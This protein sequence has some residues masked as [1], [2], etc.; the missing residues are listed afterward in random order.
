[1]KIAGDMGIPNALLSLFRAT[2]NAHPIRIDALAFAQAILLAI[3]F[4]LFLQ[5]LYQAYFQDNEPQDTSLARGLVLLTP[6]LTAIFWMVQAS[7][8]LGLAL[9]GSLS[10]IRFRTTLKRVEDIAFIVMTLTVA[11][12]LAVEAPALAVILLALLM[13]YALM[14]NRAAPWLR[15][16]PFA[17]ITLQTRA[18]LVSA[19]VMN[20]LES[21]GVRGA[22][23][24]SRTYDGVTSYV[25]RSAGIKRAM[26]GRIQQCFT[27]LDANAQVNIFYPSGR[28]G[29]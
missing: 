21:A 25:V 11:V 26:H 9:L 29:C 15:T 18:L 23:I 1:M 17:I 2:G 3:G 24:R 12:S 13:T 10:L 14:K 16:E 27:G 28:L 6:A 5:V 19:D 22:C 7:F 20:A 4:G 8:A